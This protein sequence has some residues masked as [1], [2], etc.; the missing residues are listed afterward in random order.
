[1]LFP[2]NRRRHVMHTTRTR[3]LSAVL[4]GLLL[5][6]VL[7]SPPAAAAAEKAS[8]K[9]KV[10]AKAKP[11]AKTPKRKSRS[12]KKPQPPPAVSEEEARAAFDAFTMEWMQKLAKAEDF[13]RTQQMKVTPTTDGF[14]AEYTGYLPERIIV[15][16]GTKS[17]ETPYV[18]TLSYYER[19]MRCTGK[20]K[21]D[22]AK[23]P[24]LEAGKIPVKEI[25][26]FTKGKWVY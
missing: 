18:G 8:T 6:A 13:Q 1:M 14:A 4:C 20:T 11:S 15:I 9:Q 25:F 17:Q 12:T 10:T 22:A 19:T 26:R 23:G 3:N 16:K 5:G 24:F 7:S 21:E 2:R